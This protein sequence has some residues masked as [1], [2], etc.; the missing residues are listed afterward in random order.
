VPRNLEG[1]NTADS[2]A[3]WASDTKLAAYLDIGR[4]TLHRY[5]HDQSLGFPQAVRI[6]GNKRTSLD[7][8][9]AWMRSR[10][11]GSEAA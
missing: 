5:Q 6:T 8:V 10:R 2:P 4:T 7:E 9:D 1:A 3:R 11:A